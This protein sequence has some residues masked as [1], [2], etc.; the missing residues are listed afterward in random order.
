MHE[1]AVAPAVAA[2][3]AHPWTKEALLADYS[4]VMEHLELLNE[5]LEL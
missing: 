4:E 3:V 5:L 2:S 1:P